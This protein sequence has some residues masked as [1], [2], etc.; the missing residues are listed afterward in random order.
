MESL[1]LSKAATGIW[2]GKEPLRMAPRGNGGIRVAL[3]G[4][5]EHRGPSQEPGVWAG[6]V[7]SGD[8]GSLG[9]DGGDSAG[10]D[11]GRK[12]E[13]D[14]RMSV[15]V[16][17]GFYSAVYHVLCFSWPYAGFRAGGSARAGGAAHSAKSPFL[18]SVKSVLDSVFAALAA[19]FLG[20]S[21]VKGVAWRASRGT[22]A[23]NFRL[24]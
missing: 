20:V 5:V 11:G 7:G 4:S 10:R 14:S 2:R 8:S 9:K 1:A 21:E 15:K 16:G 17:S 12:G 19:L 18:R 6:R 24:F 3:V 23:R 13:G 22:L